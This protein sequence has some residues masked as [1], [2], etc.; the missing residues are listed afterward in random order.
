MVRR[1]QELEGINLRLEQ[2]ISEDEVRRATCREMVARGEDCGCSTKDCYEDGMAH[3]CNHGT[4]AVLRRIKGEGTENRVSPVPMRCWCGGAIGQREP[5]DAKGLG[6]LEHIEHQWGGV[7]CGSDITHRDEE[8]R[9]SICVL[10]PLHL[11]S[12]DD[13]EGCQWT[14]GSHWDGMTEADR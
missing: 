5:G 4:I 3:D 10:P 14:D 11:S 2:A 6:C 1:L 9:M 8:H 7:A 13:G 12:H